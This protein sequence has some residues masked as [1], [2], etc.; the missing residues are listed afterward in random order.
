M[1][2]IKPE[3]FNDLPR[4][5]QLASG[6]ARV[7]AQRELILCFVWTTVLG[8]ALLDRTFKQG[9]RYYTTN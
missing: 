5:T 3:E 7:W 1:G 6:R 8:S 2:K 4:V 9:R